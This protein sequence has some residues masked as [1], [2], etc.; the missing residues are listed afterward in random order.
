MFVLST[1]FLF[2]TSFLLF[3]LSPCVLLAQDGP[4]QACPHIEGEYRCE[5]IDEDP[6]NY[7]YLSIS[8]VMEGGVMTYKISV[9][10][11]DPLIFKADGVE[12][13]S[14]KVDDLDPDQKTY[15]RSTNLASCKDG[16]LYLSLSEQ[17][18]LSKDMSEELLYMK[19][20]EMLTPN[21]SGFVVDYDSYLRYKDLFTGE[22]LQ[23]REVG[24]ERC[25]RLK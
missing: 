9:D 16:R 18:S 19:A 21:E 12:R 1:A 2:V 17:L 14:F 7:E 24:A 3:S 5:N 23:E 20:D 25:E 13:E 22:V 11:P 15:S 6:G 8:Q 10:E 4:T